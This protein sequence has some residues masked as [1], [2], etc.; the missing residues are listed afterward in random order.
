MTWGGTGL[1]SVANA[2]LH[3]PE[4]ADYPAVGAIFFDSRADAGTT[5][6]MM[7]PSAQQ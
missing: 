1:S 3:W 6:K 5:E 7:L 4:R 2:F